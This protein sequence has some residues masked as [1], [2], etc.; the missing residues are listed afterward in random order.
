MSDVWKVLTMIYF[1]QFNDNTESY[2]TD[3]LHNSII[4]LLHELPGPK[5]TQ[6]YFIL[7]H[8]PNLHIQLVKNAPEDGPVRSVTCRANIRDE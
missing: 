4:H 6:T 2:T 5:L 7:Q 3:I 8:I 1:R